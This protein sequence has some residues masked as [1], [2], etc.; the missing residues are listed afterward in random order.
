MWLIA[1]LW[2]TL[3]VYIILDIL[4]LPYYIAV[5]LMMVYA[6]PI[7]YL[8]KH[9]TFKYQKSW[10]QKRIIYF[11]LIVLLYQLF[12]YFI[13]NIIYS[14]IDSYVIVL[15]ISTILFTILSYTVQNI[16]IFKN[17]NA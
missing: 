5:L 6:I 17:N 12:T 14:F 2:N 13:N 9:I 10:D 4:F 11:V 3:L 1:F 16:L 8:Q 15:V 7:Y